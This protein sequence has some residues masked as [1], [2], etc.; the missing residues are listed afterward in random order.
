ML[1]TAAV[2]CYALA[3]C[4]AVSGV[5]LNFQTTPNQIFLQ[6]TLPQSTVSQ[7][8]F[9]GPTTTLENIILEALP[10]ERLPVNGFG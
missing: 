3:L 10:A 9:T 7:L 6:S 2:T 8:Q 1:K 4:S 5:N